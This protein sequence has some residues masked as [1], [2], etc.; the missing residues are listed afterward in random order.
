MTPVPYRYSSHQ[1]KDEPPQSMPMTYRYPPINDESSMSQSM[2][3]LP[4]SITTPMPYRYSPSSLTRPTSLTPLYARP[5]PTYSYPPYSAPLH[6]PSSTPL[7][8]PSSAAASPRYDTRQA[9]VL[10]SLGWTCRYC[11]SLPYHYR[12]PGSVY[13]TREPPRRELVE[14][15]LSLCQ[16]VYR[17]PT[18]T[19]TY[20][21]P[22]RPNP[23]AAVELLLQH[24]P[25]PSPTSLVLQEDK[26]LLTDY[27]FYLI[28]QLRLCR[29][30]ESDRKTRG[31]KRE[32]VKIGFGGLE[33]RHCAAANPNNSRKFFWSNV[34]RLAN[35][36]AEIPSHVLKC[37]NCEESIKNALI[38]LKGKHPEQ[39]AKLPRGSQKVFF[40]RMWRRVHMDGAVKEEE[41]TAAAPASPVETS[42]ALAPVLLAI[43]EDQDWL[44]DTDCFVR[45]NL[46][47]F[48]ATN[49]D[50][51]SAHSDRKYP[52]CLDQVGIRCLHCANSPKGARGNAVSFPYSIDGIYE[53][54]RELQK[55]HLDSCPNLP[56][57]ITKE[58]SSLKT[59]TSLSSVLRRY[60]VLAAKALGMV[61]TPDGIRLGGEATTIAAS[62]LPTMLS[63]TPLVKREHRSS[64]SE[65]SSSTSG[66]QHVTMK[67]DEEGRLTPQ[68]RKS[69]ED[70][71]PGEELP[72][73]KKPSF[74]R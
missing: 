32:N 48:S 43:P 29:F 66:I 28:Q 46:Q 64:G 65:A 49:D 59:S 16:G 5:V 56:A 30:S 26:S 45:R 70:T 47:V 52:I 36:F 3:R 19:L 9:F 24:A 34:D 25:P 2:S 39:M 68:K 50:L 42:M 13:Q 72:L 18:S 1:V 41:E 17:P 53:S 57:D 54:V 20:N 61:D 21:T 55:L 35:S 38:V 71:D 69:S 15:H 44:S 58:L 10:D 62:S 4:S 22:E 14:Q 7:H 73:K 31:G 67:Q 51:N 6:P 8:P 37:R 40:R 11:S 12:A 23:N 74:E 27:F 33:C 63:S 60:Y